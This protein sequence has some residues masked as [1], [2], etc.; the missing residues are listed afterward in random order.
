MFRPFRPDLGER[1]VYGVHIELPSELHG[2]IMCNESH[3]E[4]PIALPATIRFNG[5]Y[6][7]LPF[8][9]PRRMM[10]NGSH[11]EVNCLAQVHSPAYRST[12]YM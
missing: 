4:L 12:K 5:S 9:L 2:T 10:C 6:I 8:E 1:G 3:I 7:E 11:E